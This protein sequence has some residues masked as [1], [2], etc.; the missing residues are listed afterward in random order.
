[1]KQKFTRIPLVG[2]LERPLYFKIDF[3]ENAAADKIILFHIFVGISRRNFVLPPHLKISTE[4]V[5][6]SSMVEEAIG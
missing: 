1:M 4:R 6:T 5:F 2:N 3:L